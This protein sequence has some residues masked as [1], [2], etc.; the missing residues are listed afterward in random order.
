MIVDF[1]GV[2]AE[3]MV[4]NLMGLVMLLGAVTLLLSRAMHGTGGRHATARRPM[5]LPAALRISPR[6][7]HVSRGDSCGFPTDTPSRAP[8]TLL[9]STGQHPFDG[10]GRSRE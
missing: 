1:P 7:R 4:T 9:R 10:H 5:L 3:I 2:F 8:P 6:P